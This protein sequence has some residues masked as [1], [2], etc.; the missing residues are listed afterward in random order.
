MHL[1]TWNENYSVYVESMD[2]QH[3]KIIDIINQL[4]QALEHGRLED[5]IDRILQSLKEYTE[6]HFTDEEKLMT[7]NNYPN[8][9]QHRKRHQFLRN[10]I[11]RYRELQAKG[12]LTVD[13]ISRLLTNWLINH[14]MVDDKD[15]GRMIRNAGKTFYNNSC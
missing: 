1:L 3:Q 7:A 12:K 4:H 10:E 15:Y 9:E 14:I 13:D 8:L 6:Y 11:I 5:I 2:R